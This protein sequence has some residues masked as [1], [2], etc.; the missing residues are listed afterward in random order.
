MSGLK[1]EVRLAAKMQNPRSLDAAFGLAKIQEEYLQS[2]RKA[3]KPVYEFNKNNWQSS[4]SA[5]VKADNK[6][7][8][9]S[10]V[11]IQKVSSAQMEERRKKGL[12][13][14]CDTKW[15]RGHQCK[16]LKLFLMEGTEVIGEEG[17]LVV[18]E[19]PNF[20]PE[21]SEI[22]LYALLGSPSRGIMRVLGQIRGHWVVILLDTG[23]SHNFLDFT[24]VQTL[25]LP[26]G[27]TRILE[28][29]VANGALIKTKGECRDVSI[30]IQGNYFGLNLHVLTLGGCDVVM[31][32]QW[33]STL[34]LIKWDFKIM[35]MSFFHQDKQVTLHGVKPTGSLMQDG[36]EFFKKPVRKSLLLQICS[37]LVQIRCSN[38]YQRC[39]LC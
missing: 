9:R 2:C 5:A 31:G 19:Q 29:R 16:E 6:G 13:Y 17:V 3:Y 18:E 24:L 38:L 11:P 32:A 37:K 23:S 20:E 34:G 28:V 30:S 22:T 1:D 36:E 8:I 10:R 39:R 21:Q 4:S 12:C 26:L 7:D 27:A 15:H 14:Y 33:L 25:S 35:E